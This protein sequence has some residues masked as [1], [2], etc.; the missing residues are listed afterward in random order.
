MHEKQNIICSD[1]SLI[2]FMH[3]T[4]DFPF[5]VDKDSIAVD[6][7]PKELSVNISFKVSLDT[8]VTS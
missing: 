2:C 1:N 4:T 7:R 6:Y 8:H 5:K 3:I